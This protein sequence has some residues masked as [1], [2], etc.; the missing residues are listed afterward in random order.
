MSSTHRG[1][2]WKPLQAILEVKSVDEVKDKL[3]GID[4]RL[5]DVEKAIAGNSGRHSGLVTAKDIFV[6][7]YTLI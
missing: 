1:I 5:S 3:D 4:G 2:A 7:I 6:V